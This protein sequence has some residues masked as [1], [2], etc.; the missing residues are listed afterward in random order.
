M[1]WERGKPRS[2]L[3]VEVPF[4]EGNGKTPDLGSGV[5][6]VAR[7]AGGG[8]D[9]CAKVLVLGETRD[10]Y[11]AHNEQTC[12]PLNESECTG[13]G[14]GASGC[15]L[16]EVQSTSGFCEEVQLVGSSIGGEWMMPSFECKIH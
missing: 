5:I 1:S 13:E 2:I 15:S 9:R 10:K 12:A 4:D 6:V 7:G 16:N 3:N 8:A 14:N 11:L